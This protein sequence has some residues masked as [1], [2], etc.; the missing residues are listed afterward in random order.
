MSR[1]VYEEKLVKVIREASQNAQD[2]YTEFTETVQAAIKDYIIAL[3]KDYTEKMRDYEWQIE[4]LNETKRNYEKQNTALSVSLKEAKAKIEAY[5][6]QV[7]MKDTTIELLDKKLKESEAALYSSTDPVIIGKYTKLKDEHDKICNLLRITDEDPVDKIEDVMKRLY[8]YKSKFDMH[9]DTDT[10]IVEL[11]K[12]LRESKDICYERAEK[13][14]AQLN[15]MYG[16]SIPT[17]SR[18]TIN[19]LR[20]R[21]GTIFLDNYPVKG[22]DEFTK[23]FNKNFP[24]PTDTE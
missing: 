1:P 15:A 2:G 22:L 4:K 20:E 8:M 14:K 19:E 13:Y 3:D 7:E 18:S 12:K 5:E 10:D 23:W 17:V 11:V 9:N 21:L 6:N 16:A 24:A